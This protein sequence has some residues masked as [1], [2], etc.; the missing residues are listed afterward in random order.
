MRDRL[1]SRCKWHSAALGPISLGH[2]VIGAKQSH[3]HLGHLA[4]REWVNLSPRWVRRHVH[5]PLIGELFEDGLDL[6]GGFSERTGVEIP[7][8]AVHLGLLPVGESELEAD[9]L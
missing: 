7:D 2:L 6:R 8:V 4:V 3:G 1:S 5:V 9:A